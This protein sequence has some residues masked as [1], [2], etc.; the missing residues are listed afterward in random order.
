MVSRR[1]RQLGKSTSV[2]ME[3]VMMV[4]SSENKPFTGSQGSE[5]LC[6]SISA[7]PPYWPELNATERIR[8]YSPKHVT[9][10][11]FYAQP[12]D[13]CNALFRTFDSV[14]VCPQQIQGLLQPFL[15]FMLNY[16]RAD[17][18][19]QCSLGQ[20]NRLRRWVSYFVKEG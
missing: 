16:L 2:V 8:N 4:C 5:G 12:Q 13:L 3:W 19:F 10:N 14:R 20:I 15:N 18:H 17:K 1:E 6:P 9:H 7:L 11:R